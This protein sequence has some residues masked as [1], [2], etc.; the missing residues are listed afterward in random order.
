MLTLNY[1]GPSA[2]GKNA[3]R[4]KTNSSKGLKP[5]TEITPKLLSVTSVSNFMIP[6]SVT[7][8]H[9]N[10]FYITSCLFNHCH[11]GG[12]YHSRLEKG[13]GLDVS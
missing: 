13:S 4:I 7:A 3:A 2:V 6:V 10:D 8:Q 12:S 11:T 1:A 9:R 5:N